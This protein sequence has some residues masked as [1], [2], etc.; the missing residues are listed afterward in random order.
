MDHLGAGVGLLAVVGD[1]DGI[2]F[3]LGI[4]AFQN[5]GRVFPGDGGTCFD[6]RP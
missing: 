1:G 5:A 2:E 6:L 3:A 4:V